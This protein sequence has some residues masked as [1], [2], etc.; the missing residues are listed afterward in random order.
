MGSDGRE[1]DEGKS[2]VNSDHTYKQPN[3][4]MTVGMILRLSHSSLSQEKNWDIEV[5]DLLS[6]G[7]PT[8]DL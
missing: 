3:K 7:V 8:S 5:K 6:D 2:S 4:R 1:L